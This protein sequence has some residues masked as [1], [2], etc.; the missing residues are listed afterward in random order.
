M[1]TNETEATLPVTLKNEV[2]NLSIEV[3]IRLT[4]VA[5]LALWC[6]AIF[7]PFLL[8]IIWAIIL[9]VAMARPFNRLVALMGGRRGLAAG[10]FTLG[11]IVVLVLPIFGVVDSVVRSAVDMGQQLEAETIQIPPARESVREWPLVGGR[12]YD[13]W[14]LAATNLGEA[15]SRFTPQIKAIGGWVLEK[16]R[17][18]LGATVQTVLA[19]IIAGFML[20]YA[21]SGLKAT[22]GVMAR[23]GG[24]RGAAMVPLIGATI[25]SVALGVLGIAL[26]Q[27]IMGGLGMFLVDVPAWGLWTVLILILAIMQLPPLVVLGPVIFWAFANI[28]NVGIAIVFTVWSL[29]VSVSDTFLKPL[30]LG[31][32]LSIPMPVIL[33]GAIGGLILDGFIGLFTGA[34]VLAVGY[35]LFQ[36]WMHEGPEEEGAPNADSTPPAEATAGA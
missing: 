12:V 2:V 34:V 35:E 21:E 24:E 27:A 28:D 36:A 9:A 19:L 30:F 4:V 20:A 31:R 10:I 22:R 8:P 23:L 15:V 5:L 6:F 18:L 32:G 29:F 14:N 7:M 1:H 3:A 16:M 11:A 26:V 13:A 33:I 25:R 17:G